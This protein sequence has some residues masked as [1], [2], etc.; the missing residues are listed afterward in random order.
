MLDIINIK[1]IKYLIVIVVTL[2]TFNPNKSIERRKQNASREKLI[3][4]TQIY[5]R[6]HQILPPYV[7]NIINTNLYEGIDVMFYN[8]DI[9]AYHYWIDVKQLD[10][11]KSKKIWIG[12]FKTHGAYYLPAEYSNYPYLYEIDE[13]L[14]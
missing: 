2:I 1:W 4:N 8:N 11:L 13:L 5:K 3:H 7:K 12:V 14:E 10:S 9:T 6:L